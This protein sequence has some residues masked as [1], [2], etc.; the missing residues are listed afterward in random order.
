MCMRFLFVFPAI[1]EGF[2]FQVSL[3]KT[4]KELSLQKALF[5]QKVERSER[6]KKHQKTIL[7][8][9]LSWIL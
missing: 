7:L 4:K 5:S 6:I 2:F 1:K 3:F 8:N 9:S